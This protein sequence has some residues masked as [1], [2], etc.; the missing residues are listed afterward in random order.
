MKPVTVMVMAAVAIGATSAV[1]AEAQAA[2]AATGWTAPTGRAC[3]SAAVRDAKRETISF[4]ASTSAAY[5][6]DVGKNCMTVVIVGG[7][8]NPNPLTASGAIATYYNVTVSR[9]T[10]VRVGTK[11]VSFGRLFA[12]PRSL[13]RGAGALRSITWLAQGPYAVHVR[14]VKL[15]FAPKH[16]RQRQPTR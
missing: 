11:R 7:P 2:R 5:V 14:A 1:P 3:H 8:D 16:A 13:D 6:V 10:V 4:S 12:S 15:V 9:S